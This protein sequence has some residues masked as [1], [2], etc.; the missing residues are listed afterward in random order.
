VIEQMLVQYRVKHS[1]AAL[2]VSRSAFYRWRNGR[3]SQRAREQRELAQK[4]G[5]VFSA[6]AQR[7]G[8]PRVT[9][10]LRQEGLRVGKL[11]FA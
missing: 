2:R 3:E 7:Y 1:C 10:E 6:H 5:R 9:R 11:K 8:S 4:I